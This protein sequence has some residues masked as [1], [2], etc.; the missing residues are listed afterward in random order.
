[1]AGE[2]DKILALPPLQC[3]SALSLLYEFK[4]WQA[5]VSGL[6]EDETADLEK[7]N[8]GIKNTIVWLLRHKDSSKRADQ[9]DH[10][11]YELLNPF[12]S[13]KSK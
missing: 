10:L 4:A 6:M 12:I 9:I 13:D 8:E 7:A 3:T 2:L 5:I 1:M 11:Y